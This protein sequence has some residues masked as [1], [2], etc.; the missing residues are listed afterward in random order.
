MYRACWRVG[1]AISEE[2]LFS[3][4]LPFL[5]KSVAGNLSVLEYFTGCSKTDHQLRAVS[6]A[7]PTT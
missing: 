6:A 2:R 7:G 1:H 3:D 4:L 5:A